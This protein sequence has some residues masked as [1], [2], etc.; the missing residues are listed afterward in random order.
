M[1]S[2][3]E[4]IRERITGLSPDDFFNARTLGFALV[5]AW[6][7]LLFLSTVNEVITWNGLETP[8]FTYSLSSACLTITLF[9][10]ALG[11]RRFIAFMRHPL[12]RTAGPVFMT[13][14]TLLFVMGI[15]PGNLSIIPQFVGA[16]LTGIGSG[17]INL[18][19]GEAYKQSD[20]RKTLY[21][22]PF[23]FFLAAVLFPVIGS[24][25][26]RVGSLLCAMLPL[27]SGWVLFGKLKVWKRSPLI[28]PGS[29][30]LGSFGWR[31]GAVACLF[32]IADGVVRVVLLDVNPIGSDALYRSSF[33]W[34]SLLSMV[35][36]Y[37]CAVFIRRLNY[38]FMYRPI[39][40]IMAL[41]F[42]LL[43]VIDQ[44]ST[45]AN[46]MALAGYE[47]FSLFI[48]IILAE[49]AR[50]YHLS[51]VVVFGGG[52]GMITLGAF[53][54]S[55]VA[56]FLQTFGPFS[57]QTFSTIALV[58]AIVVFFCYM[59]IFNEKNL[60]EFSEGIE[61]ATT[62]E[63]KRTRPFQERCREIAAEYELS[64][65]ETEVMILFAKGRSTRH[66]QEDLFISRGTATTHLRHIY[67]KLDIHDKQQLL[68][69]IEGK[70]PL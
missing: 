32:G 28:E 47:T 36:I 66:I 55:A 49:A 35:I 23:A 57:H 6:I 48:W 40:L 5:R 70:E 54:G 9:G 22:A 56:G 25:P 39:I 63:P 62:E 42:M 38:G 69:L 64:A 18:G 61:A 16:I 29:L 31:L 46:I 24:L 20:P 43:P 12:A 15:L 21:S 45:L 52:W 3:R 13:A 41:F 50:N 53:L 58:A 67:Q 30:R 7:Y 4:M 33:I 51:S 59:F 65:R 44:S 10:S 27:I 17:L 19:W 68:D 2:S 14:G 34:A 8:R 11:H 1:F 60:L 26:P 37:S